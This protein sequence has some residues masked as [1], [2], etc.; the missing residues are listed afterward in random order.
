VAIYRFPRLNLRI[1]TAI[2]LFAR[3]ETT[4][5]TISGY[6]YCDD[7]IDDSE[8][9]ALCGF[10]LCKDFDNSNGYKVHTHRIDMGLRNR[11]T[12]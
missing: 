10:T 1:V 2:F 3:T 7:L 4:C 6:T 5:R 8:V 11:K 12:E 9:G